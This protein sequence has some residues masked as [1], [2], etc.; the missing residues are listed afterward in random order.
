MPSLLVVATALGLLTLAA[1][2]GD[3]TSYND[4]RI[5]EQLNLEK[6]EGGYAIDGDPFCEVSSKLLNDSGEVEQAADRD[7]LG[8]VIASAQGNAGIQGVAPFA[9]DCRDKAKRKLNELDPKP[10]EG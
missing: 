6:S 5:V 1:C 2:G 4:N 8:L 3:E 7:K 9:P 10:K